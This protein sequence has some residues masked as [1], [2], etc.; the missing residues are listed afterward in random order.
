M[1]LRSAFRV[2]VGGQREGGGVTTH[3]GP[4]LRSPSLAAVQDPHYSSAGQKINP[5]R[6]FAWKC[7][8]SRCRAEFMRLPFHS[9][10][11]P[12]CLRYLKAGRADLLD[13]VVYAE[14]QKIIEQEA[15]AE[16]AVIAPEDV[17]RVSGE[18]A[19][20]ALNGLPPLKSDYDVDPDS[21]FEGLNN[22]VGVVLR[23]DKP[24]GTG[25]KGR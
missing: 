23:S 12:K 19:W 18:A 5:D 7:A 17:N 8:S 22:V 16:K 14:C 24:H 25:R 9:E 13:P 15:L 1:R 2:V 6:P 20:R 11:C 4:V 3:K 21:D 10:Y